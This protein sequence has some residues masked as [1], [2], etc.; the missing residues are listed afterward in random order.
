[1]IDLLAL[2]DIDRSFAV[3]TALRYACEVDMAGD[4]FSD[5]SITSFTWLALTSPE[6]ECSAKASL[7]ACGGIC[8]VQPQMVSAEWQHATK[9]LSTSAVR[10]QDW[11]R[12]PPRKQA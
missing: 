3:G 10:R 2:Q 5:H 1:M 9:Y 7:D 12:F 6:H 4:T 11:K 8:A